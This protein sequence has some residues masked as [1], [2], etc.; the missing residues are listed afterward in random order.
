MDE[1]GFSSARFP[2]RKDLIVK[3]PT[4]GNTNNYTNNNGSL[5]TKNSEIYV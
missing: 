5:D 1:L 3:C 2:S 4:L